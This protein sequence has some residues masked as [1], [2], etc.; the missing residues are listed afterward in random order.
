MLAHELLEQLVLGHEV[1]TDERDALACAGTLPRD[2]VELRKRFDAHI[3]RAADLVLVEPCEQVA[4][5]AAEVGD[6][7][8]AEGERAGQRGETFS[9]QL[10][11]AE[12]QR[13]KP[14]PMAGDG[15]QVRS[16][17]VRLVAVHA[18]TMLTDRTTLGDPICSMTMT[19]T[20]RALP[21]ALSVL[22]CAMA[23]TDDPSADD[24]VDGETVG[25][26][27]GDGDP[28]DGDGDGDGDPGDGDGDTSAVPEFGDTFTVI[29][30]AAD[31]LSAPRDLEFNPTAP[32]Q[33]WTYNTTI[34]GTVIYFDPGTPAQTS[35]VRVD[36]YGQ[37]FMAFVSSAAFSDN[38]N[39][40]SCQESRDEWNVGPQPPDDFMGPTLWSSDLD[41]FAVVG[42]EYPPVQLEGSH[43]DML[44]QS[45]LCMGIAHESGNAFWAFDG[46]AG[47]LVRY[48][49][50]DDHGPGG[51]D[52]SDG[53]I[54][55]YADATVTR[56]ANVVGHM[57]LD[58]ATGMLYVAD[59]GGDRIMRLDTAT[60]MSTGTLPGD[61]DGADYTGWEGADW[62]VFAAGLSS[63]AGVALHEGRLF[64]SEHGSADIVAFDLDGNELGRM[65]TPATQLMG[66]TI[67]PDGNIWYADP[68]ANEIVRVEP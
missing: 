45:P 33:L 29:G 49:F 21:F 17:V 64:V 27:D 13:R 54:R 25:D 31:G 6:T 68:G 24:G 46:S 48:D 16:E 30:T 55:R 3:G 38:G 10:A 41:I 32:E 58:H 22:S 23:C 26:G 52:H 44:H 34:H 7:A 56:V 43:L 51:G 12:Q 50:V 28:G 39:F 59:T 2:A 9:L 63:P 14:R 65:S 18:S 4:V 1:V 67:G 57:E 5:P 42:Q 62:Q 66:I 36:A 60:G 8:T 11:R 37:H 40:A 53:I 47:N 61:W 35:E 20:I 19:M 15:P